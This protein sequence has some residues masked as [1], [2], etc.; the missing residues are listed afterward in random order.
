MLYSMSVGFSVTAT[1]DHAELPTEV[2]TVFVHKDFWFILHCNAL[3]L[4]A[5]NW[6]LLYW[7]RVSIGA[8]A[9][10]RGVECIVID[11]VVR[12]S[13]NLLRYT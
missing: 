1:T 9:V 10:S 6:T 7:I 12:E 2:V 13:G 11:L 4:Q 8:T 5:I 3:L